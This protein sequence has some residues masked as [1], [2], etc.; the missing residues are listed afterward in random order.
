MQKCLFLTFLLLTVLSLDAH[1]QDPAKEPARIELGAQFSSLSIGDQLNPFN[2][3]AFDFAHGRAE[4]GFG[5]RFTFNLNRNVAL[6]AEMNFFPNPNLPAANSGGR[7]LQGQFGVK[8]GKR[9]EKFGVFAKGRPGFLSFGKILTQTDTLIVTNFDGSPI[10]IPLLDPIR[11]NFFSVDAG[12][13]VELYPSRRVLVRFDVGDTMVYVGKSPFIPFIKHE[14]LADLAHKFQFSSGVAFRFLNPESSDDDN[15]SQSSSNER[16]LEIGV[17][18]S[19]LS[20]VEFGDTVNFDQN[21]VGKFVPFFLET[22][23]QAGFGGRLSYNF[24]RHVAAEVQT[25][26]YPGDLGHF[27]LGHVGGWVWQIQA[28]PKIGRRFQKFGAFGKV[29]PGAVSF[30]D[31]FI[32]DDPA[33]PLPLRFH[34]ARSTQW[35]L[36]VGGVLEFYPSPRTMARFDIGDT[37]IRIGPRPFTSGAAPLPQAPAAVTHQFQLSAG[38][39]FRF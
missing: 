36:D 34:F 32:L 18:F 10:V 25:D 22:N 27:A 9:F 2:T 24:T 11:R 30:S 7:L 37:M 5:G 3:G 13:V 20:F 6:E 17:Q 28:G 33:Q 8:V 12:A 29:R 35:S 19:S 23:T 31:T 16:K 38:V 39:G 14:R 26:F 15:D 4:P 1:A 21:N